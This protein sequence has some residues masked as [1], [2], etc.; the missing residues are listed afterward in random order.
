MVEE[1]TAVEGLEDLTVVS[2]LDLAAGGRVSDR[3]LL[4]GVNEADNVRVI[5]VKCVEHFQIVLVNCNGVRASIFTHALERNASLAIVDGGHGAP[6]DL[7]EH[8]EVTGLD[9]LL[10][11]EGERALPRE[12]LGLSM[13]GLA[14]WYFD[15][16]LI[17]GLFSDLISLS[18]HLYL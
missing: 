9:L 15:E 6:G 2:R 7:L 5:S 10:Y 12:L 11:C 8:V 18:K 17:D 13:R 16:V 3:D 1:L 4:S 14:D